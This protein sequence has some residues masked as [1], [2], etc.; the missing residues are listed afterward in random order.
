LLGVG[1]HLWQS[2]LFAAVIASLTLILRKNRARTRYWLWLAASLKLLLPFSLLVL[3][4][5][6]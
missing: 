2:T 6:I 4:G 1:N 3:L 5:A